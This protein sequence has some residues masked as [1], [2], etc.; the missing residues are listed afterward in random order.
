MGA[1]KGGEAW[2]RGLEPAMPQAARLGVDGMTCGHCSSTV[3]SALRGH[4]GVLSASVSLEDARADVTFDPALTSAAALAEAVEA[5]GF[6]ATVL[7]PAAA[8]R[9]SASRA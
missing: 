8:P 7:A 1:I 4:A 3:E 2:Q 6:D 5:V 9:A